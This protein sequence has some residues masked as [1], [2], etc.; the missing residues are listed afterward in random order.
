MSKTDPEP[1]RSTGNSSVQVNLEIVIENL[2]WNT[3]EFDLRAHSTTVVQKVLSHLKFTKY[4][5]RVELSLLL[6]GDSKIIELNRHFRYKDQ[7]T[8]VLSFPSFEVQPFRWKSIAAAKAPQYLGDIAMSYSVLEKESLERN[9]S[10]QDHYTHLLVHSVL[11]LLGFDHI[12]KQQ[13]E[14]MMIIEVAILKHFGIN[15]PYYI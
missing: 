10:L 5:K 4:S 14:E 11:H 8:N 6:T 9:I 7:T 2:A 12:E 1:M 3:C 13:E 15:N